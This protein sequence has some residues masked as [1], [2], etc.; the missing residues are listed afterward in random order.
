MT[1]YSR[2]DEGSKITAW[3]ADFF[4]L[5][6]TDDGELALSL[7]AEGKPPM[8]LFL[9]RVLF[10]EVVGRLLVEGRAQGWVE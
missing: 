8:A 3:P 10:D 6:T 1:D 9:D 5:G 2:N 4:R 7:E